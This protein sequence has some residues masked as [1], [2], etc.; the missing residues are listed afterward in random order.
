MN[1]RVFVSFALNV[2]YLFVSLFN[3]SINNGCID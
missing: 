1:F 2:T 3:I